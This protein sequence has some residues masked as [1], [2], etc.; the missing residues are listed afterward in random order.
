MDQMDRRLQQPIRWKQS[1]Y[2]ELCHHVP[3]LI[4]E[5]SR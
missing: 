2:K 4:G 5:Y 1:W 3:A